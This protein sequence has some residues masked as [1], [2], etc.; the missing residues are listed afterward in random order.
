M[1]G[2]DVDL[3]V[4]LPLGVRYELCCLS[5]ESIASQPSE[6]RGQEKGLVT[7]TH[8][9]LYVKVEKKYNILCFSFIYIIAFRSSHSIH[10]VQGYPLWRKI[11]NNIH[12]QVS[13]SI[14]RL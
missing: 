10:A 13:Q 8:V 3:E 1:Q 2:G 7:S 4:K 11:E 6:T 9:T 12:K 14:A 5:L